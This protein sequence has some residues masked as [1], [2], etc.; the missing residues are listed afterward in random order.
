MDK[1]RMDRGMCGRKRRYPREQSA[2]VAVATQMRYHHHRDD[3]NCF[4]VY[5]CKR[6]GRW[7][8]TK[9]R[10]EVRE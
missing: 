10:E 8:L 5:K 7:H 6:C 9:Q 2:L 1:I 4:R 3:W